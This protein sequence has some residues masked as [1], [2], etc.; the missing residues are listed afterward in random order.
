MLILALVFFPSS[1]LSS[2]FGVEGRA[3][4]GNE[5]RIPLNQGGMKIVCQLGRRMRYCITVIMAQREY[6]FQLGV[7]LDA[8][9]IAAAD[10]LYN[11]YVRR[12]RETV[13]YFLL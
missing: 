3:D 8:L 6:T 11:I 2:V 5:N 12:P 9:Q 1:S 4:D 13:L 10:D 7:S